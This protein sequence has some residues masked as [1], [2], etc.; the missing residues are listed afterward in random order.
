MQ[1]VRFGIQGRPSD[2]SVLSPALQNYWNWLSYL[3]FFFLGAQLDVFEIS[4]LNDFPSIKF[5]YFFWFILN[6]FF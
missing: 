4:A 6:G 3:P 2:L 5:V 1:N